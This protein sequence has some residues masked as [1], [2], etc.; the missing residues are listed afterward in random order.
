MSCTVKA[1]V[2]NDGLIKTNS[3]RQFNYAQVIGVPTAA[4]MV[5]VVYPILL[6]SKCTGG[7][8]G[9]VFYGN[10]FTGRTD[11]YDQNKT[12]VECED[13]FSYKYN[14]LE[15]I[16]NEEKG[17]TRFHRKKGLAVLKFP[18]KKTIFRG[19][20]IWKAPQTLR[21][22]GDDTC[23]YS[24]PEETEETEQQPKIIKVNK[25]KKTNT[26][27]RHSGCGCGSKK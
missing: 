15:T 14:Q 8:R 10:T 12:V 3:L 21:P 5:P 23:C 9:I 4:G 2:S 22:C 20:V 18:K 26:T 11:W 25:V 27:V 16:V 19:S 7:I 1:E 6:H 24:Y 17:E 13:S